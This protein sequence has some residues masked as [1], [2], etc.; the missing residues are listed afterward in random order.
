MSN[1]I[2][3]EHLRTEYGGRRDR[4]SKPYKARMGSGS[5]VRRAVQQL[6]KAGYVKSIKGKGRVITPK[7]R[8]FIDNISNEVFQKTKG[9][10]PGLEKY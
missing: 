3:I 8:S 6:E 5:I 10:Y 1:G 9:H 4:G 7:G 2:G